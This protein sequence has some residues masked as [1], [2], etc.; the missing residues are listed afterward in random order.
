MNHYL[1]IYTVA[2]DYLERRGAYREEHLALAREHQQHGNLQM[3]GALAEPA[4]RAVLVFRGDS[5]AAAE[6]FVRADPY[7]KNGL[8][9]S[10]EIRK[11]NVV[12]GG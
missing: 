3:G 4:D 7:V 11:W 1:L 9:L 2:P 10:W 12:V 5:P 6:A 8:V